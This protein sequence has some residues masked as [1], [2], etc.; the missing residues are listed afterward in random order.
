[1]DDLVKPDILIRLEHFLQQN[2]SLAHQMLS[3]FLA[4]NRP[5]MLRSELHDAFLAVCKA[6]PDCAQ[7]ILSRA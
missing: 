3:G 2:P 4:L 5:L 6:S 1:M 7:Q